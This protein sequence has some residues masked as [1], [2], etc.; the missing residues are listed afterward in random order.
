MT[1]LTSRKEN[2]LGIL[3]ENDQEAEKVLTFDTFATLRWLGVDVASQSRA[4]HVVQRMRSR[5]IHLASFRMV[6]GDWP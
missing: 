1:S 5:G 6:A 2:K 3:A 4:P